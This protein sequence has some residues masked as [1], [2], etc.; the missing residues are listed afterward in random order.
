MDQKWTFLNVQPMSALG[1]KQT[2][3][4][5]RAMSALSP[6]ADIAERECQCPLCAKSGPGAMQQ[7]GQFSGGRFYYGSYQGFSRLDLS[8]ARKRAASPPVTAR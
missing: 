3:Q 6:K 8:A 1:Q 2:S 4:R 7:K 5:V